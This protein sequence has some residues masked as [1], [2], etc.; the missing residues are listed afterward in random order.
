MR[1]HHHL[2]HH[3]QVW[4][5][6]GDGVCDGYDEEVKPCASIRWLT[7]LRA[8]IVLLRRSLHKRRDCAGNAS[9]DTAWPYIEASEFRR[10]QSGQRVEDDGDGDDYNVG[11]GD[12]DGDAN[13]QHCFVD[14]DGCHVDYASLHHH[15]HRAPLSSSAFS[16]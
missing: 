11:D 3:H 12:G 4:H 1:Q 14:G 2:Q 6:D 9:V 7:A 16:S 10:K 8:R 5:G 13:H 15:H